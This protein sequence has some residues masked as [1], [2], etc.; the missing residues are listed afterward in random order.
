MGYQKLDYRLDWPTCRALM[1]LAEE[2]FDLSRV[3]DESYHTAGATEVR[4]LFEKQETFK[5]WGH[6]WTF[7]DLVI[8]YPQ[9]TLQKHTDGFDNKLR[10]HIPIQTNPDAWC[11]S[12]GTWEHLSLGNVY[13]LNPRKPHGAIN[14]GTEPRIH[15]FFDIAAEE[16]P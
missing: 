8:L 2:H 14:W 1:A 13:V 6:P 15:L 16:T 3:G 4:P 10:R 9:G 7:A 5:N 12:D 11:Y